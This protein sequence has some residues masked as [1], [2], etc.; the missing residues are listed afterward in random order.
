MGRRALDR[1]SGVGRAPTPDRHQPMRWVG[2]GSWLCENAKT[3][4]GD[5]RSYSSKTALTVKRA[6]ELNLPNDPKNVILAAFQSFAFLHS[7]GHSRRPDRVPTTSALLLKTDIVTVRWHVSNVP[8]KQ[9]HA[10][11]QAGA[12]RSPGRLAPI[13][14]CASFECRGLGFRVTTR[15]QGH[16]KM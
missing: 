8:Q 10:L 9:A 6:S 5:R 2:S 1:R 15:L 11:Q 14:R 16:H 13:W 3:R 7:Q 4:D 12:I